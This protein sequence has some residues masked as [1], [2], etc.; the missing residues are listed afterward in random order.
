MQ[1]D[2]IKNLCMITNVKLNKSSEHK[3][4]GNK[5]FSKMIIKYY[6]K[7]YKRPMLKCRKLNFNFKNLL[8]LELGIRI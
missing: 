8:K 6:K 5:L 2:I 1:Y 4:G 3:M 7:H